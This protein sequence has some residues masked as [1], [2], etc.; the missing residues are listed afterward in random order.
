MTSKR[1]IQDIIASLRRSD[2]ASPSQ[3]MERHAATL[4]RNVKS[5]K[6][7]V[8][9]DKLM[10]GRK[11]ITDTP[12][13]LARLFRLIMFSLRITPEEYREMAVEYGRHM[14][15]SGP[16]VTTA[17]S[18]SKKAIKG[19]NL[20]MMQFERNLNFIGKEIIGLEV[21]IRDTNTGEVNTYSLSQVVSVSNATGAPS[22]DY[23]VGY[24][25]EGESPQEEQDE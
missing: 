22:E 3:T 2:S 25:D 18:N 9:D 23:G 14:G 19:K 1:A 8:S 12:N 10:F 15:K 6:P 4:K 13:P 21:T 17:L 5:A 24:L 20:T 7:Q 11:D 16:E